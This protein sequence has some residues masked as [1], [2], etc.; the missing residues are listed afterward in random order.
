[1]F[2]YFC[3]FILYYTKICNLKSEDNYCKKLV[4]YST[5][6]FLFSL[7]CTKIIGGWGSAPD[8]AGG[9]YSAPPD[10][11]AVMG[12]DRDFMTPLDS[13]T[14]L[15]ECWNMPHI[16][17]KIVSMNVW[18]CLKDWKGPSL[19]KRLACLYHMT[20]NCWA[21]NFSKLGSTLFR[22]NFVQLEKILRITPAIYV[23]AYQAL[24]HFSTWIALIG[25]SD[26]GLSTCWRKKKISPTP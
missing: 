17:V 19:K 22:M 9:A 14:I 11:L 25:G 26:T 1:M 6:C 16:W 23:H 18:I 7:K 13:A 2:D 5:K 21:S 4:I 20:Y 3:N 24:V 8:P 12:W 10:P 15:N